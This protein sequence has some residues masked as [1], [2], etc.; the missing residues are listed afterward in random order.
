MIDYNRVLFAA[1]MSS[2]AYYNL[3][4]LKIELKKSGYMSNSEP[5]VQIDREGSQCFGLRVQDNLA[6][7]A[8]RGTEPDQ[9]NDIFADIKAWHS[10]SEVAGDVHS[11]FK[12]ELDKVFPDLKK[13]IGTR[14]I[15]RQ[16]DIIITGHSL[17]AAIATIAACRL[18]A[19]GYKVSLYTFG[20]PRVG[21]EQFASTFKDIPTYRFVN[22]NDVVCKVPPF[23]F[24]HHVD[25]LYYMDYD[26]KIFTDLTWYQRFKDK[27]KS[28]LRAWSKLQLFSG[29]YDHDI[30]RYIKKIKQHV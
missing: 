4:R 3:K 16:M 18:H 20:S 22:N 10:D 13:W 17:G 7:I 21:D 11:G 30:G 12:G 5:F 19:M 28:R 24:F 27:I 29:V 9:A 8:F 1:T 2:F 25:D 15:N 26:G 14:A 6:V 23:G